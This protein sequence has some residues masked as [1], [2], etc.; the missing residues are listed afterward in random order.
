MALQNI[1]YFLTDIDDTMT[2]DGRLPAQTLY[3][4][5]RLQ[6]AGIKVIPITGRPAGWC[7][8]IARMWPVDAV[9]GE[10]GAFYFAYNHNT[11]RMR[12]E[13]WCDGETRA[14]AQ[15]KLFNIADEVFAA[16]P[17]CA[18][19]SDQAFRE[20]D[21]AI[22]FCEDV[23]RLGNGVVNAIASR[24]RAA[25]A[26]AKIS[27]IHVNAWFGDYDKL[28]MTRRCLNELFAVDISDVLHECLYIGD[29]P[30]DEPMFECFPN[31]YGVNN[32]L[33]FLPQ[34]ASPPKHVLTKSGAEGFVECVELVLSAV[35]TSHFDPSQLSVA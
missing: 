25:G 2:T 24:F 12:K 5:E 31:S 16:V 28:T 19:A 7:D 10:N 6:K 13:Y 22:D 3:A 35:A 23:P 32:V 30:N 9:V 26:S 29:S 34:M 27:S 14:L 1:R 11:K 21:V 17:G 18:F 4:L 8:H 20:A 15:K 33:P